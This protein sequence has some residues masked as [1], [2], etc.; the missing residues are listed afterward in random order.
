MNLT[1]PYKESNRSEDLPRAEE[2]FNFKNPIFLMRFTR[3]CYI[4]DYFNN[5][6]FVPP[7]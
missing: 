3:K 4:C 7:T 5:T 6:A 1:M 2:V